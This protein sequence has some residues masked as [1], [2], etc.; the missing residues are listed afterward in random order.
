MTQHSTEVQ[1]LKNE[2]EAKV[3]SDLQ[4]NVEE[5]TRIGEQIGDLRERLTVLERE[6]AMLVG[7]QQA[8][9][10]GASTT[11]AAPED[12][13]AAAPDETPAA[14][15]QTAKVPRARRPR[16]T[17]A[18]ATQETAEEP[19]EKSPEKKSGRAAR[20]TSAPKGAKSGP[21]SAGRAG[22]KDTGRAAA[23]KPAAKGAAKSAAPAQDDAG[24]RLSLRELIARQLADHGEP[25]SASEVSATLAQEHPEREIK[26]NV[27]RT[28][29]EAL[30]AK[31]LVHRS[32]QQKSVFYTHVDAARVQEPA[33]Q[34][35]GA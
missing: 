15:P 8:I 12:A 21:K 13:S 30:V 10:A 1:N 5:Q 23:A 33:P 27:V 28:T 16:G 11:Q 26:G 29:L 24:A 9:A 34:A 7:V 14:Q 18:E 35:A 4:A 31:G 32:K 25:R 19:A 22:G 6:Q 2:Y 20:K 17:G 3:A